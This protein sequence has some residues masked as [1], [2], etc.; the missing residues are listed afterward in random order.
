MRGLGVRPGVDGGSRPLE[1]SI[2]GE[3][4]RWHL[5]CG[6]IRREVICLAGTLRSIPKPVAKEGNC[7]EHPVKHR[8]RTVMDGTR[9]SEG[10]TLVFGP[11]RSQR[12]DAAHELSEIRAG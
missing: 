12:R 5:F 11:C 4:A 2:T 9:G 10:E 6:P 8:T 7:H 1:L 3:R